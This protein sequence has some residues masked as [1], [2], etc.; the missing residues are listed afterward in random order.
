[1]LRN[2]TRSFIL[3]VLLASA[4]G[5]TMAAK[6]V[7]GAPRL[8]HDGSANL[9]AAQNSLR[10]NDLPKALARASNAL[11]TD[12]KSADVHA[13]L[14]MIHSRMGDQGKAADFF[15][16]AIKLAP[17]NGYILNTYGAWLCEQGSPVEAEKHFL[18]AL[19]DSSFGLPRNALL[20][21]GRCSFRAAE[22]EKSERYLR[23]VLELSAV[24]APA[25]L[26]LAQVKHA[27]GQDFEARAFIQ[28]REA[29]GPLDPK[30]YELAAA[31]EA[32]A[33]DARS[34]ERYRALLREKFPDHQSPTGEGAGRP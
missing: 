30:G 31:I 33:G 7:P 9:G 19:E 13:M 4:A 34:A 26:L 18:R 32:G 29:L 11:K 3:G 21:A 24:D 12:P 8:S 5:Q 6:A 28:R 27:Q 1:M 14:A 15:G 25:L 17:G 16:T 22:L 23:R 2:A 10:G 20:N